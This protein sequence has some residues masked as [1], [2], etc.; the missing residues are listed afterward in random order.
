M[1]ALKLFIYI[2]FPLQVAAIQI[3]P[4]QL[5]IENFATDYCQDLKTDIHIKGVYIIK[6][7]LPS[8]LP[9]SFTHLPNYLSIHPSSYNHPSTKATTN[10]PKHPTTYPPNYPPTQKPTHPSIYPPN[11]THPPNYSSTQLPTQLPTHPSLPLCFTPNPCHMH[12]TG[13]CYCLGWQTSC[14]V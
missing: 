1:A 2:S 3:S 5:T 10:P 8:F 6:V 12:S 7:I 14:S 13:P 11:Y 9:S 4:S